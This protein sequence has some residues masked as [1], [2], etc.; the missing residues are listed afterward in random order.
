MLLK[1]IENDSFKLT[2]DIETGTIMSLVLTDNDKEYKLL[3]EEMPLC[4]LPDLKQIS[5]RV[6][7]ETEFVLKVEIKQLSDTHNL[8]AFLELYKSGYI[9]ST[10]DIE[11]LDDNN[12]GNI[13]FGVPLA[14][15]PVFCNNFQIK[16]TDKS[17]MRKYN[18]ATSVIFS[19][20]ERPVT[21]SVDFILECVGKGK[22]IEINSDRGMFIGWE[23]DGSALRKKGSKYKNR[24]CLQ[25]SGINN[26][27]NK[28]R[29]QRIYHWYG[30]YPQLPSKEIVEEMAEYGC[31]ILI[32]HM[33]SFKWIDGSVPCDESEMNELVEF[34]H[35]KS[36]KMMFY[37]QPLL[38]SGISPSHDALKHALNDNGKL[39][40]HSLKDTQ[41]VFYIPNSDY[42][43]DELCLRCFDAYSYIKN[44]VLNFYTKYKFDGLYIDFA[45]PS[46]AV[47][48]DSNHNHPPGIFNFYDYLRMMRD[49]RQAIGPEGL[50]I[51]HGG[52]LLV[53]SDYAEGFDACLTGEGQREMHPD[54]IGVQ[55]GTAPTL[56]TMHRRKE[57]QFRS[58]DAMTSIVREGITPHIGIGILGKSIMATLDPAHTPHFIALWQMWRAF[59]VDKS[60]FLNYL[61]TDAIKSDNDEVSFCMFVSP[62]NQA[63]VIVSNGGG[64]KSE[65]AVSVEANI[66]IDINQITLNKELNSW[67]L[68][69]NTYET[70]RIVP[71][72]KILNGKIRIPEIG[73]NEFLGIIM[74]ADMPPEEMTTLEKHLEG[75]FDRLPAIYKSKIKR[76]IGFDKLIA[77]FNRIDLKSM[78]ES[79]FMKGRTME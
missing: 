22:K 26:K 64:A 29:G 30:Y 67:W 47:C 66:E 33:P 63:L 37:C 20:D 60:T 9:I 45:W 46:I 65:S 17:D 76:L 12:T 50:M 40:W 32:L 75:R 71:G 15:N 19:V 6:V 52:S 7:S 70:F 44:S 53:S 78:T 34:A 5:S 14:N 39:C 55:T 11:A 79:E 3:Y 58:K 74:S 16:H 56:W 27:P 24:W 25:Y 48:T 31:S 62:L 69:G 41:I 43:C 68:K 49:F 28:I 38:I 4:S 42:D 36:I 2:V 1:S 21:N 18:R 35:G 51:G 54:V 61:T 77:D 73:I 13:V 72:E 57:K 59:P 10:I 8:I 23:S